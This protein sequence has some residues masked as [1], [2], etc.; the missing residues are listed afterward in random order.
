[1]MMRQIHFAS[2]DL[3]LHSRF[4]PGAGESVFD[5]DRRIAQQTQVVTLVPSLP[6]FPWRPH[7]LLSHPVSEKHKGCGAEC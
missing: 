5:V 4:K 1:M 2:V 6:P 3:E 7:C